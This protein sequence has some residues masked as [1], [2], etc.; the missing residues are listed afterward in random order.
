MDT[1]QTWAIIG[2]L[3]AAVFSL[4]GTNIAL[5]IRVLGKLDA[6]TDRVASIET[7]LAVIEDRM[8]IKPTA[9]EPT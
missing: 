4:V 2:L 8:G 9:V 3:A 1:A 5:L 6:L 7:R